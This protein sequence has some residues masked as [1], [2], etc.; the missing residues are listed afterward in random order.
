[1]DRVAARQGTACSI[2]KANRM[3]KKLMAAMIPG[4]VGLA[5][6]SGPGNCR[7]PFRGR[8]GKATCPECVERCAVRSV[9]STV[10]SSRSTIPSNTAAR[11]GERLAYDFSSTTSGSHCG[12]ATK[13]WRNA[14]GV[15]AARG[16]AGKWMS[17]AAMGTWR[18]SKSGKVVGGA[19]AGRSEGLVG[20]TGVGGLAGLKRARGPAQTS[21]WF[22]KRLVWQPSRHQKRKNRYRPKAL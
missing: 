2:S 5:T 3:A 16:T 12:G 20:L 6:G 13:R 1:M 18:G 10:G 14:S 11:A 4:G 21:W 7:S 17:T 22:A 19:A 8:P 9:S 15:R